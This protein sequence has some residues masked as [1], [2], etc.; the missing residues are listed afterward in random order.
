VSATKD[1]LFPMLRG[2]TGN[3]P[4]YP[5]VSLISEYQLS[6]QIKTVMHPL[7]IQHPHESSGKPHTANHL[8]N[9]LAKLTK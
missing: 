7:S 8:A 6:L 4:S 2:S 9:H 3:S 1:H 5:L